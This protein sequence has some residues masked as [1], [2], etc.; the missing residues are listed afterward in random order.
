MVSL[1]VT[2]CAGF[3]GFHLARRLLGEGKPVIVID[4]LNVYYDPA[5]R[6]RALSQGLLP[7]AAL[8]CR[9]SFHSSR[10]QT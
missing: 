5:L 7:L 1:L 4:N 8:S 6:W 3:V 10:Q 9:V 2:G